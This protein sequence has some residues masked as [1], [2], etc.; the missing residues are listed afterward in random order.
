MSRPGFLQLFPTE[1]EAL[2]VMR[3]R[4]RARVGQRCPVFVVVDGPDDDFAV[5]DLESA[6]EMEMPYRWEA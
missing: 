3:R 5:V 1:A 2:D 4:N 6:I